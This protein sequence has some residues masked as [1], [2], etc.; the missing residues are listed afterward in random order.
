MKTTL[1]MRSEDGFKRKVMNILNPDKMFHL[2]IFFKHCT[3]R[4]DDIQ[5]KKYQKSSGS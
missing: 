2:K 4:K 3:K 1:I 5:M